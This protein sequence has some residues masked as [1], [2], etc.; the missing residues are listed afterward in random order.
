MLWK[1]IASGLIGVPLTLVISY[2]GGN[3]FRIGVG[4]I[5]LF[6]LYEYYSMMGNR[7]DHPPF[8]F[9]FFSGF[10]ILT[11]FFQPEYTYLMVFLV[12]LL[13]ALASFLAGSSRISLFRY[14]ISLS[15]GP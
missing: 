6:G 13:H 10:L 15:S 11:T 1:R 4:I 14:W 9:G 12:L 2:L 3:C 5:I 8:F 7:G